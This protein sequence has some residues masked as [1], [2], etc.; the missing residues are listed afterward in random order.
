MILC[1]FVHFTGGQLRACRYKMRITVHTHR[2]R[3]SGGTLLIGTERY[4]AHPPAGTV[5]LTHVRVENRG[6][7]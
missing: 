1:D 7:I 5:R 4:D 6:F 2:A 3:R